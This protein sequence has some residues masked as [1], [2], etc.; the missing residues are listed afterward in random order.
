MTPSS[1]GD[2]GDAFFLVRDGEVKCTKTSAKEEVPRRLKR[3]IAVHP[4][5][6]DNTV[7]NPPPSPAAAQ[8]SRRLKRG[9]FFGELALIS[10]S[11]GVR[12]VTVTTTAPTTLL[13]LE[14]DAFERLLGPLKNADAMKAAAAG[15]GRK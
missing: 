14:R 7:V 3:G 1:Q 12:A 5:L 4:L 6:T 9:D 15:Q 11:V 13:R 2:T 8:V 10:A